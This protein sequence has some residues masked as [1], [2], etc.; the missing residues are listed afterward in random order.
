MLLDAGRLEE[1]LDLHQYTM[2]RSDE[3]TKANLL[4]RSIGKSSLM[5]PRLQSSPAFHSAF[6]QQCSAVYAANGDAALDASDY[7]NAIILYSAA[8]ELGFTSNT[9]FA[10]RSKAKSGK[11][12]WDE[13]LLDA[14]EV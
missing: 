12:L 9:I 8:I 4:Q 10:N 13:A 11:M 1:A 5:V 14:E 3:T 2:N 6:K 7:E